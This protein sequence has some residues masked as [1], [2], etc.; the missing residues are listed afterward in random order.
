[1]KQG[2]KAPTFHCRA[3]SLRRGLSASK[4]VSFPG[5][6][7]RNIPAALPGPPLPT[8]PSQQCCSD[9]TGLGSH[10]PGDWSGLHCPG[11]WSG[12]HWKGDWS[13]L[14]CPGHWSGLHC[15]GDWSGLHC[16]GDWSGLHWKGHWS[17]LHC[18]PGDWSGLHCPGDWSGLHCPGDW[19]GLPLPRRLVWAPRASRNTFQTWPMSTTVI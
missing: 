19:S 11:H 3:F 12:L 17:G 2:G 14:H 1:M 9:T 18:P 5:C 6:S 7:D 10:C 13:G 15:P 4:P 16:P 8:C